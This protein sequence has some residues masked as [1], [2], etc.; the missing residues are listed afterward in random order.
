MSERIGEKE[1]FLQE[2]IRRIAT[3]EL[4]SGARLPTESELAAEYGIAKTQTKQLRH[5]L[6]KL[7]PLW[8]QP[9]CL[10]KLHLLFLL[11]KIRRQQVKL[12]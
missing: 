2:M 12:P 1:R 11:M 4:E 8:S 6:R 9:P 5:C 7:Q 10:R 3:G